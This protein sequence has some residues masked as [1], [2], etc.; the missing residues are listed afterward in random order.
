[1]RSIL[2]VKAE[3]FLSLRKVDVRLDALNVLVGPN[4]AGKSNLLKLFRFLGDVARRDLAPAIVDLGDFEQLLFRSGSKYM[5]ETVKIDV[6][7]IATKF[8]SSR[9]YDEY[10]LAFKAGMKIPRRTKEGA[11]A[12]TA[13]LIERREEIVLKRVKGRGRRI[14]LS[15]DDVEF[16]FLDKD[17]KP[18]Q[19]RDK[20]AILKTSSGLATLRRLGRDHDAPQIEELAKLFE[21]LRL[22]EI[23]V[24]AARTPSA[25]SQSST[26]LPDASNLAAFLQWLSIEERD[27][28]N[29]ICEDVRY[30]LPSFEGFV[31]T[32]L[33]GAN[34]AVRVDIRE[35]AL[36]G[37]TPLGAAS[38]GT[39]RAIALFAMLHDPNPPKLTCLEEV[40]HGLHPNA[41]DRI[42]D[43][44]REASERTQIIVATHSPALVNRLSI[45]ELIVAERDPDNGAT[46]LFR[47]DPD[48]IAKLSEDTGYRLGELW[49]SGALGGS[50]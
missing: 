22:F 45:D 8:A 38:F 10:R 49:F 37:I 31:F 16:V 27:A 34:E 41:L 46:N 28:F 47:P 15:G 14:T 6:Q 48:R 24:D 20:L 12:G 39:I 3:N 35:R 21:S 19:E 7:A 13:R 1:M 40:D 23:E 4:G 30:V 36:T 11:S 33:G 26:L 5:G 44:L 32:T 42:V 29:D 18:D 43:R 25:T 2:N 17:G 9:G 50:L